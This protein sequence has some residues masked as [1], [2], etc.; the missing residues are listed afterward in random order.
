MIES[1]Q[2]LEWM[3]E[4]EARGELRGKL[5][6][7]RTSLLDLL[8]ARFGTLPEAL[9]QRIEATT[10]PERLHEAHRQALRLGQLDD[11]QL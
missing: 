11:L 6:A 1:Q 10:D 2:V 5:R 4:G 8:E 9:T 7:C 3:A